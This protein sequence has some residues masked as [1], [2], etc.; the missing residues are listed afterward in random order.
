MHARLPFCGSQLQSKPAHAAPHRPQL[1]SSA[2]VS[3]HAPLQQAGLLPRMHTTPQRP[4]FMMFERV[5]RH[6]PAQHACPAPQ[7]RPHAPQFIASVWK[8]RQPP[9][10]Q[11]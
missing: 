11:V 9:L 8:L 1:F 2:V 4:Q 10:Q 7:A 5:S 3:T 6:T